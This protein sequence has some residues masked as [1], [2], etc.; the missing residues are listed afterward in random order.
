[1]PE[2]VLADSNADKRTIVYRLV[3]ERFSDAP[4]STEG[5]RKYGGRWNPVGIGILYTSSSPELALLEQL[6][7]LPALPY[8]DLPRLVLIKL[9]LPGTPKILEGLP[10]KWRESEDYKTNHQLIGNWL[11]NPD[12]IAIGVPSAVVAESYN[13]L[14]HPL[15][16]DYAAIQVVD[17]YPFSID[18]RLWNSK[19]N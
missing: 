9:A 3:K 15:H 13:Y 17:T 16:V 19:S 5:A 7:H 8:S 11:N 12:V 1:M 10:P 18:P 4:L 6:V 14:L 2:S